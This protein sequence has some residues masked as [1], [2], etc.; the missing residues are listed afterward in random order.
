MALLD[1]LKGL[2]G[3]D[4]GSLPHAAAAR[5]TGQADGTSI[6][7]A[8]GRRRAPRARDAT[9]AAPERRAVER[10]RPVPDCACC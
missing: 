9:R 10:P 3:G 5:R 6:A 4:G 2:F 1:R 8:S 7:C